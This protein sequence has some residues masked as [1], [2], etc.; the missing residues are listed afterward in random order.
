VEGEGHDSK[1]INLV[2]THLCCQ[3]WEWFM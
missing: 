2:G 3:R 1:K